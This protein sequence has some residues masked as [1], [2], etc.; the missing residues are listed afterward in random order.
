MFYRIGFGSDPG[1]QYF[2]HVVAHRLKQ[3]RPFEPAADVDTGLWADNGSF[4]S[5]RD[6]VET[7]LRK[8]HQLP[9][10][11]SLPGRKRNREVC[12]RLVGLALTS[13]VM[14]YV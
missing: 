13:L 1:P 11:P 8:W 2:P 4:Y 14:M 7:D 6:A 5:N 10:L 12:A 9:G 3:R